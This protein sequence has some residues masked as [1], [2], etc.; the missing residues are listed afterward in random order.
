[1]KPYTK[2]NII[3]KTPLENVEIGGYTADLMN[4]FFEKRIFGDY[5]KNVVYKEAESAFETCADDEGIV[6]IW[7]KPVLCSR[8]MQYT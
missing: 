5:G 2:E 1:M 4:V 8:Q 3:N 6:G 7:Q